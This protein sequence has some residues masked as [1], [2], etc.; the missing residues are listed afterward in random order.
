MLEHKR[1]HYVILKETVART[2]GGE[3]TIGWQTN[4]TT[5]GV[6]LTDAGLDAI[7]RAPE[8]ALLQLREQFKITLHKFIYAPPPHLTYW[9]ADLSEFRNAS[10]FF[11][12]PFNVRV[13]PGGT[14]YLSELE[15]ERLAD[16]ESAQMA[17]RTYQRNRFAV[18]TRVLV[19]MGLRPAVVKQ[20]DDRPSTMGE[21]VHTV[22]TERGEERVVG[23]DM[24]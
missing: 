13:L 15:G 2:R 16:L 24:E 14:A 10:E 11:S 1:Y 3:E 21:Y 19:S 23:C 8:D 5:L 20:V 7:G 17:K 6:L 22:E 9:L 4:R 18:G 12:G